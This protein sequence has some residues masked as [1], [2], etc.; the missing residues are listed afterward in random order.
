MQCQYC[1]Q[2]QI[3][4]RQI[5]RTIKPK[6]WE[7]FHSLPPGTHITFFGGEPLLYF[8]A[9]KEIMSHRP[10]LEYGLISNGKL[11]DE[12]KMQYFNDHN[13]SITISWDGD[14]SIITR[15]YNVMEDNLSNIAKLN[16]LAISGVVTKWTSP[17]HIV[18]GINKYLPN[19]KV[20][21]AFMPPLDFTGAYPEFCHIEPGVIEHDLYIITKH[22]VSG[23]GSPCEQSFMYNHL[24]MMQELDSSARCLYG[25]R[26][27]NGTAILNIDLDGNFYP[28]HNMDIP[29]EYTDEWDKTFARQA[30]MCKECEIL[31]YC[32]G[33]CPIMS[34]EAMK[35]SC[36]AR[37]AF[38]RGITRALN[39]Y[40]LEVDN[41]K[42]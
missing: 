7:H 10:D 8:A 2:R 5:P 17:L 34:D 13:V 26:C 27:G 14:N 1:C 38:Y 30:G 32:R 41:A 24:K 21:L 35:N 23:G 18:D 36:E 9:I 42:T 39:E 15:G 40:A 16:G 22:V 29:E 11:L 4:T 33:G 3:R 20:G 31:N 37:R 12:Q 6:F 19:R 28:C 25:G